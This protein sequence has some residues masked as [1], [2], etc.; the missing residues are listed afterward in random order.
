MTPSPSIALRWLAIPLLALGLS[1]GVSNAA[2]AQDAQDA[3][4]RCA[5]AHDPA[6]CM[7]RL[8]AK[9]AC[10]QERGRE[11][12][13]CIYDHMPPMDCSKV[14]DSARCALRQQA[15]KACHD[16]LGKERRACLLAHGLH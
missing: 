3:Q 10:R 12:Q 8:Q 7:A 9:A 6:H 1:V 14:Q 2:L 15:V 4:T 5:Q 13:Q 11:L 16:K